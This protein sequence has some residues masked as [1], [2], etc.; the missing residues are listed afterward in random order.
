[1]LGAILNPV[2]TFCHFISLVPCERGTI[3]EWMLRGEVTYVQVL[4]DDRI[5]LL[6]VEK[7][8]ENSSCTGEICCGWYL[9]LVAEDRD[10]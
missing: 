1:M 5:K 3:K 7:C 4:S 6:F 9:D 10:H 8:M 2:D